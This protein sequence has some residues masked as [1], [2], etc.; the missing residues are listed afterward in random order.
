M[1]TY[2]QINKFNKKNN[3]YTRVTKAYYYYI[4]YTHKT[5]KNT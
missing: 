5:D 2:T 1:Y 3:N 4:T